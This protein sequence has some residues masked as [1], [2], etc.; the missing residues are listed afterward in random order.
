LCLSPHLKSLSPHVANGDRVGQR[1][2]K[3][4]PPLPECH[5]PT[6]RSSPPPLCSTPLMR[7]GR[8]IRRVQ[9]T[10]IF[11][12][13][14]GGDPEGSLISLRRLSWKYHCQ[15]LAHFFARLS[16]SLSLPYLLK[17]KR[18]MG[19][20]GGFKPTVQHPPIFNKPVVCIFLSL[21]LVFIPFRCSWCCQISYH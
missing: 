19:V 1:C 18:G 15:M 7:V 8:K 17:R 20:K 12:P 14:F 16:L 11:N 2:F 21:S 5:Y 4:C 10:V 9:K 6:T 13:T 3:Q